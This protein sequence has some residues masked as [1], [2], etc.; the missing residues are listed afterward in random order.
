LRLGAGAGILNVYRVASGQG[1]AVGF[2]KED[3][4]KAGEKKAGGEETAARGDE[5][6]EGTG[7]KA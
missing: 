3:A 4:K 7:T 6:G 5:T 1:Y 2:R